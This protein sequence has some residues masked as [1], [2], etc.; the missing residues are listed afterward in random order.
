MEQEKS[1]RKN[2][3]RL[4]DYLFKYI[5]GRKERKNITLSFIN[6]V[7]GLEGENEIVD[8]EFTDR[9]IDPEMPEGKLS[10]LDVRGRLN[11]GSTIDIEV[12][13]I[14]R[15]DT[16][17]RFTFYWARDFI[18][19]KSGEDYR[20]LHRTIV[21]VITPEGSLPGENP[22]SMYGIYN[23]DNMHRLTDK[24]EMH[25]LEVNKFK[26]QG[27]KEMKRLE[28]WLA[29]LGN[30]LDETEMEEMA[31]N[32]AAIKDALTYEDIFMQDDE[33]R[34]AYEKRQKAI[35]DYNYDM[36]VARDEGISE[37][38]AI[39]QSNEKKAIARAMLAEGMDNN[40][41]AKITGLPLDEL[42]NM[43]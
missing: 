3:N 39:G 41:I 2:I 11:D 16:P 28:R 24:F 15:R 34:A 31:M 1:R 42:K 35:W 5:F 19:I 37:G 23:P 17:D 20:Q 36:G 22:H 27:I 8:I 18:S 10:T 38:I 26:P 13:V 9:E 12:Q 21:I 33:T 43:R 25:F 32:D 4:N 7:M 29:Y 6:A 40:V 14:F 30:S